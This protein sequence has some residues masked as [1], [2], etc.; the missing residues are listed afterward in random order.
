MISSISD[1]LLSFLF[2]MDCLSCGRRVERYA[3]TPAC[4]QC[5]L[6]TRLF[7]DTDM[8][9]AR[10]GVYFGP[11]D[12]VKEVLCRNCDEHHYDEAFACGLYEKALMASVIHLKE[13]PKIFGSLRSQIQNTLSVSLRTEVEMVVPVPLSKQR[14][15]ERGFNQA[16]L[17]A[18]I[19]A[20]ALNVPMDAASLQRKKDTPK[21]RAGM[22]A[23]A[24]AASVE[25]AFNVVRPKLIAGK[26]VL[27]VD[28]VLTSGATASNCAEAL[29]KSGAAEVTVFTLARAVLS[30]V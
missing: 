9:C 12:T 3:D 5:W 4:K 15:L 11:R 2:P 8:L 19:C 29:K 7:S 10:C 24:R 1:P 27:L 26:N 6:G 13:T 16:E 14:L 17:I 22:D 23:K 30:D 20:K 18:G 21:H 28:D 25:G